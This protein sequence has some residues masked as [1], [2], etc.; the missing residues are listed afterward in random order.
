MWGAILNRFEV[1]RVCLVLGTFR[2]FVLGERSACVP[3]GGSVPC[4]SKF[5]WVEKGF[6]EGGLACCGFGIDHVR[7]AVKE[8]AIHEEEA[9]PASLN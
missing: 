6:G 2:R 9:F 8:K 7:R 1:G 5:D 4:P 3:K